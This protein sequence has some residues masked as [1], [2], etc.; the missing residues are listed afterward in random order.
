MPLKIVS[1]ALDSHPVAQ[2]EYATETRLWTMGDIRLKLTGLINVEQSIDQVIEWL[3][4]KGSDPAEIEQLAPYFGVVWPS[5]L[6]LCAYLAQPEIKQQINGRDVIELGCGLAVP[7]ILCSKVG[8]YCTVVDSHP[9]V[10]NFLRQNV[11]Q[12]EPVHLTLMSPDDARKN[13]RDSKRR[14]DWVLASDVLYDRT[15]AQEFADM[16]CEFANPDGRCVITDP[17]RAYLQEFVSA[18]KQRG[19]IDELSSWTVPAA[20]SPLG[21]PSDIFVLVF[22]RSSPLI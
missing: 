2:L 7:S 11:T 8:G 19:W 15:L 17:G 22:K 18:M 12:N 1:K 3:E 10:A 4:A 21:K 5:A 16:F 6:A 9:S 14:F 13:F 20:Q